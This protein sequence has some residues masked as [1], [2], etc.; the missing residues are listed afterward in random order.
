MKILLVALLLAIFSFQAGVVAV[1]DHVSAA[2]AQ[3]TL[4]DAGA[5]TTDSIDVDEDESKRSSAIEELSDYLPAGL[6]FPRASFTTPLSR[7]AAVCL[8]SVDLPQIKPP[9]RG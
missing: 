6:T 4:A 9:P 5:H 1:S 3:H 2:G 7:P 8:L